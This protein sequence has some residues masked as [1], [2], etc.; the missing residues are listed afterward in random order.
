[1]QTDVVILIVVTH[2][3]GAPTSLDQV[4]LP[5]SFDDVFYFLIHIFT[6]LIIKKIK[7]DY[8]HFANV[9]H[10]TVIFPQVY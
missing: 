1:M 8:S 3:L 6:E 4:V 10:R 5:S 9:L 7:F 2:L